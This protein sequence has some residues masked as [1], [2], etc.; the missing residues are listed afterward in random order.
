[1]Y[2]YVR[3]VWGLEYITLTVDFVRGEKYAIG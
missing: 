1:M 3:G 2:K